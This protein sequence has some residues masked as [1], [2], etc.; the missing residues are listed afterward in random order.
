MLDATENNDRL[1]RSFHKTFIPERRYIHSMLQFASTG[2]SGDVH[3]I[4]KATG[5][6]TGQ[7]SGKVMPILDYCRGM[8]LLQLS[9]KSRRNAVKEPQLTAFGRIVLLEDPFL[10]EPV[11]QW[12][13]HLNF[14]NPLTGADIWYHVFFKGAHAL[15]PK[16]E[17]KHLE[18]YLQTIY[19]TQTANLIGTIVRMYGD[20]A[21]FELCGA[22]KE[23]ASYIKRI[24]APV[25]EEMLW[26]YGAWVTQAMEIFFPNDTQV[27]V[28]DLDR[29]SGW[30]TT[31]GWNIDEFQHV[32]RMLENKGILSVD[33]HMTP[34]IMQKK[35]PSSDLW[36]RLYDDLI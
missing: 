20:P 22:L 24:S 7:S 28:T 35:M 4:S 2:K 5:I 9:E 19:G 33:R 27:T 34:W 14:C 6:P 21:S 15:G 26:C 36:K 17:K 29:C 12:M 18:N 30:K 10:K 23:T 25:S 13:A 1:P 16:F 31:P 32:L 8:G 3:A 11:T